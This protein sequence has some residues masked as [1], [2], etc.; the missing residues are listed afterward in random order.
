MSFEKLTVWGF[1]NNPQLSFTITSTL[2]KWSQLVHLVLNS[3]CSKDQPNVPMKSKPRHLPGYATGIW[4]VN[5][6]REVGIQYLLLLLGWGIWNNL[7]R[8]G[9]FEQFPGCCVYNS[10]WFC[11]Y[12]HC[13]YVQIIHW[14]EIHF[15]LGWGI[16]L[17]NETIMLGIWTFFFHPGDKKLNNQ[18]ALAGGRGWFDQ[19][20]SLMLIFPYISSLALKWENNHLWQQ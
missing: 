5:V 1:F 10:S 7:E 3:I 16:W 11:G 4:K 13:S 19:Y 14:E 9:R 8:W 12:V 15:A 2:F 17:W 18:N 20:A 6:P